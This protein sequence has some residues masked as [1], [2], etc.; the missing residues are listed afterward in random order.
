MKQVLF[1]TISAV[2][3][4]AI[5]ALKTEHELFIDRDIESRKL[6]S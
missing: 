4:V 6:V 3:I 2:I 1:T 5:T